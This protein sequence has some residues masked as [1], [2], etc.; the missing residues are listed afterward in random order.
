MQKYKLSKQNLGTSKMGQ[1]KGWDNRTHL[2]AGPLKQLNGLLKGSNLLRDASE[3]REG[4]EV[5]IVVFHWG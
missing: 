1:K 4:G 5:K 3:K 2:P